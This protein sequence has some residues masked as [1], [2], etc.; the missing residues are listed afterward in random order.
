MTPQSAHL[1]HLVPR[2]LGDGLVLFDHRTSQTHIL[3]PIAAELFDRLQERDAGLPAPA[4]EAARLLGSELGLPADSGDG[5]QLLDM[6]A[7][8][9]IIAG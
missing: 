3:N 4:G 8:L 1:T 2:Y 6:F 9:G 5:R 7:R